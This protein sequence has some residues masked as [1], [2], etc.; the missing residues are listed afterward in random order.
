MSEVSNAHPDVIRRC[1]EA[2]ARQAAEISDE[3]LLDQE[4]ADAIA[5]RRRIEAI[6]DTHWAGPCEPRGGWPVDWVDESP[7]ERVARLDVR[8]GGSVRGDNPTPNALKLRARRAR[9]KA[10]KAAQAS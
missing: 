9:I 10:A 8:K 7:W 2:L 5:R 3:K 6:G 1:N 4:I